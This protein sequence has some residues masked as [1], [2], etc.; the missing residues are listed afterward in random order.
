MT[1]SKFKK[2][3]FSKSLLSIGYLADS[4]G[5][6]IETPVKGNILGG[7]TEDL[8][9]DTSSGTRKAL[10]DKIKSVPESGYAQRT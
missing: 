5:R 7:L 6:I 3:Q 8:F 4:N 10:V 2:V 9:F 1:K